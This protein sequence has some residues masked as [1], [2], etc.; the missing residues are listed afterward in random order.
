[1]PA[2]R[3][4]GSHRAQ[5]RGRKRGKYLRRDFDFYKC[6]DCGLLFVEPFSGFEIYDDAYYRGEGADPSVDYET[7]YRDWRATQRQLEFE[8]LA[9]IAEE[10]MAGPGLAHVSAPPDSVEWLD[11]GC[12]AGGFLKYL[13]ERGS[14]SGRGL[15]LAGHDVGHYADLLEK[16]DGFR[17]LSLEGL[18]RERDDRYDV[19]SMV[20][21]AEHLPNVSAAMATIARILKPGGLLLLTTGNMG[22]AI[23]RIQGINYDYCLPEVHVSLFDPASLSNLY[24]RHGLQPY[25]V[26]YDGA[27]R[28]KVLKALG[29]QGLAARIARSALKFPPVRRAID[30]LY[31]VSAMPCAVKPGSESMREAQVV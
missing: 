13:R 31:G 6:G 29:E 23:P 18:A 5:F 10:F 28:F 12:G 8:D 26:R 4:C 19:I 21:V 22:G 20:E 1:M 9:R 2:C 24:R 27:V 14:I 7:E 17:I 25:R 11:F 15:V 3:S 30:L 16:S